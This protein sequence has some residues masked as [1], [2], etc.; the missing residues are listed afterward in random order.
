M[1]NP[2]KGY[3]IAYTRRNLKDAQKYAERARKKG[4]KV[5]IHK[6]EKGRARGT[7][8]TVYRVLVKEYEH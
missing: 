1:S 2:F 5:K 3:T 4:F 6:G 8:R 7:E